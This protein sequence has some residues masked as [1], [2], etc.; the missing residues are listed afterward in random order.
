MLLGTGFRFRLGNGG[1]FGT[2]NELIAGGVVDRSYIEQE[3][4]R[5]KQEID[6]AMDNQL[7]QLEA[8]LLSNREAASREQSGGPIRPGPKGQFVW[9]PVSVQS[10]A[11]TVSIRA[12][13]GR[14]SCRERV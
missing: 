11:G 2:W 8:Q 7:A 3:A 5:R 1:G 13:I 12:Q 4:E 10:G 14:A 6:R 9:P